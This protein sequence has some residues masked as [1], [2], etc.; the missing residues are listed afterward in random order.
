MLGLK[1]GL[2]YIFNFST[3]KKENKFMATIAQVENILLNTKSGQFVVASC[4]GTS[5]SLEGYVVNLD[6]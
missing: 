5:E 6:P 2:A 3:T 4:P 1:Y